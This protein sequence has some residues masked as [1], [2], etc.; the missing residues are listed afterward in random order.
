[1][2]WPAYNSSLNPV[3]NVLGLLSRKVYQGNKQFDTLDQLQDKLSQKH[4]LNV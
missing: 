3:E 4:Y 2:A 1:M